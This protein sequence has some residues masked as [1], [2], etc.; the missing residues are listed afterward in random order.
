[1]VLEL[2]YEWENEWDG[3]VEGS[4]VQ[5]PSLF[6]DVLLCVCCVCLYVFILFLLVYL[7]F[8]L[9]TCQSVYFGPK[10]KPLFLHLCFFLSYLSSAAEVLI[11]FIK[12]VSNF[13]V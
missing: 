9:C 4:L 3:H 2:F 1:M 7:F 5:R 8:S 6:P 13:K 11:H 10:H 12:L